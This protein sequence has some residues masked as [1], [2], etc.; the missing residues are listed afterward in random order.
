MIDPEAYSGGDACYLTPSKN[1]KLSM[2]H[3]TTEQAG[4]IFSRVKPRLAVYPHVVP[5][6]CCRPGRASR[7]TYSG[8]LEVGE[9]LMSIEIGD[10]IEVYRASKSPRQ[11]WP[12][13]ANESRY[14]VRLIGVPYA[15][16]TIQTF[17][18]NPHLRSASAE[19]S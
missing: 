16:K 13:T 5:F 19:S 3:T 18:R 14:T 7:K 9:D 11:P 6:D 4:T 1:R 15:W 10:R 12:Q 2:H 17:Q 8:P